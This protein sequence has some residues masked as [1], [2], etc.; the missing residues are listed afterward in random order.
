LESL[1]E[2]I[3]L[4]GSIGIGEG[5]LIVPRQ[6]LLC[7]GTKPAKTLSVKGQTGAFRRKYAEKRGFRGP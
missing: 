1:I 3:F 4:K 5:H 6:T 7:E 2:A